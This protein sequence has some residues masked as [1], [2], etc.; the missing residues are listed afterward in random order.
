[1]PLSNNAVETVRDRSIGYKP[2]GWKKIV[3]RPPRVCIIVM[4][5]R[6][7]WRTHKRTDKRA[8]TRRAIAAFVTLVIRTPEVWAIRSTGR[9]G[10]EWSPC[11]SFSRRTWPCRTCAFVSRTG[12]WRRGRTPSRPRTNKVE[13]ANREVGRSND[14]RRTRT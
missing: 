6:N 10:T 11:N 8:T 4:S 12:R 13:E 1:M 14:V 9:R 2:S 7:R 5:G 3:A